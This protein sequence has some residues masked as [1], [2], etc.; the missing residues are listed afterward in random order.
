[1][2]RFRRDGLILKN[3]RPEPA[4]CYGVAHVFTLPEHRRRGYA[5]HMMNLLHWVIAPQEF[6]PR[7]FPTEWGSRPQRVLCVPPGAFSVLYSDVGSKFYRFC[8]TLPNQDDGWIV[9]GPA[10]THENLSSREK[11]ERLLWRWLD[12]AS[13][14]EVWNA[15][16][17]Y[18]EEEMSHSSNRLKPVEFTFLPNKGVAEFQYLR[19]QYFWEKMDPKPVYWG[20]CACSNVEASPDPKTFVSWTLDVR[21]PHSNRF[22]ITQLRV[23]PDRFRELIFEVIDFAKRH[24][25]EVIEV[26]NLAEN[27]YDA[28]Q[29]VGGITFSR[30]DQL[31][32]FNWYGGG[33]PEDVTWLWNE[34]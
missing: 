34:K 20:L 31:P 24:N 3:T 10:T 16:A 27:L 17:G 15:D 21:P 23:Q 8:G 19:L 32:C 25:V 22:I 33:N 13:V 28:S 29:D 26:W 7:E 11:E 6:L 12:E 4:N 1:M 2:Y 30:E 18:M 5:K 9:D 14:R